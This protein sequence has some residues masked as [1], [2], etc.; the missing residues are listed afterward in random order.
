MRSGFIKVVYRRITGVQV[1]K[2]GYFGGKIVL[3]CNFMVNF[4]HFGAT[5]CLIYPCICA[6]TLLNSFIAYKKWFKA[7]Y[8]RTTGVQ[9]TISA[10]FGE[11][12]GFFLPF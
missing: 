6:T 1:A 10:S 12:I 7:A 11:K 8:G 9:A 2:R 4:K 3:F 5:I